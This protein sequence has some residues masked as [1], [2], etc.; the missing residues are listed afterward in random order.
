MWRAMLAIA[1]GNLGDGESL[2]LSALQQ[3]F[4]TLGELAVWNA[5]FQQFFL[6]REQ[7]QL[8]D[9]EAITR[10]F[11]MTNPEQPALAA[12]LAYLLA[13]TGRLDE[14]ATQLDRLSADA[15]SAIRDRNWPISW[16]LLAQTAV[17]VGARV[18]AEELYAQGMPFAE[19]AIFSSIGATWVGTFTLE[20]GSLA[21]LLDRPD[22]EQHIRTAVDLAKRA[23][24]QP[25]IHD[26]NLAL[27]RWQRA[28]GLIGESDAGLLTIHRQA[29][30]TGLRRIARRAE[31]ILGTEKGAPRPASQASMKR[32]DRVWN[33]TWQG[34][35]TTIPDAKGLMDI[36]ILLRQPSASI[37]A[38]DLMT[39]ERP[40]SAGDNLRKEAGQ[41]LE[42]IDREALNQY[43][44]RLRE[45][46]GEIAEADRFADTERVHQLRQDREFL[47]AE[48]ARSVNLGGQ[49]RRERGDVERAR[50]AVEMRVSYAINRL[51]SLDSALGQHFRRSIR[52][53]TACVYEP[54][55]PV[56]WDVNW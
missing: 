23:G 19:L 25:W 15:F 46:D 18:H 32:S 10:A 8:Q 55:P 50:K 21:A 34:Q 3:G 27:F 14:A 56:E 45:L 9:L 26:A 38:L 5:T 49:P 51:A 40:P 47:L 29:S 52:T 43:R 20:L 22:A 54:D 31:L 36:A 7:D 37:R 48:I 4:A 17:L 13:E 2:R 12:G 33:I 1:A 11:V 24:F 6:C 28:H 42:R 39:R 41:S 30:E 35:T 44:L 16:F 53:G